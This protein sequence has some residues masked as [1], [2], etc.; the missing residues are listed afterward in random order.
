[1]YT[2]GLFMAPKDT[3]Q[4]S[5]QPHTSTQGIDYSGLS[6]DKPSSS[7]SNTPAVAGFS[8]EA[9]G[10]GAL[11]E[12]EEFSVYNTDDKTNYTTTV[13]EEADSSAWDV[14]ISHKFNTTKDKYLS[15]F[16][17]GKSDKYLRKTYPPPALP[18]GFKPWHVPDTTSSPQDKVKPASSVLE[19]AVKLGITDFDKLAPDSPQ[20]AASPS[21]PS[22]PA[23]AATPKQEEVS[24][25][26]K[27][28]A[29]TA[30]LFRP[31][32]SN[33]GKEDRYNTFVAGEAI[34]Y[35]SVNMTDWEQERERDEFAKSSKFFKPLSWEMANRFTTAGNNVEEEERKSLENQAENE[36]KEAV[37]MKMFG[38][39]TRETHQWV[40]ASLTCKR[41]DVL[42]PYP[43]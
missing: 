23:A 1:M 36:R 42:N 5:L 17:L 25:S 41:F 40:P 4:H 24:E 11:E 30:S 37:R 39:L 20:S 3:A 14:H 21:D 6:G 33:P 31:F 9:F 38:Q 7:S 12:A 13:E 22:N 28:P 43:E 34:D 8:G 18:G 2:I 26:D 16:T 15:N 27:K 32:K 10:V 19:R 29:S 35:S